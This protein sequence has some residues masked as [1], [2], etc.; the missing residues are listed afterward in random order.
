MTVRIGSGFS[1]VEDPRVAAIEAGTDAH[2]RLGGAPADLV[3]V[4]CGGA[5]LGECEAVLE[6][7]GEALDPRV[8]VGCGAGGVLAAGREDE[9]GGAIVV[10]AASLNGGRAHPFHAESVTG[11]DGVTV[12]GLPDISGAHSDG[13]VTERDIIRIL[14]S[15]KSDLQQTPVKES[16]D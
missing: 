4:F 15:V 1:N 10:W 12:A 13:I 11:P 16:Y 6:G 3:F 9:D 7:V 2:E 8:L 14:G 5:Y